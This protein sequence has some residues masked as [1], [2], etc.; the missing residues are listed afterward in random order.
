MA[1]GTINEEDDFDTMGWPC[2]APAAAPPPL[3]SAS[4]S[5]QQNATALGSPG[6]GESS[7]AEEALEAQIMAEMRAEAQAAALPQMQ[8]TQQ[9]AV[10]SPPRPAAVASP[11]SAVVSPTSAVASPPPTAASPQE[12]RVTVGL[13]LINDGKG[14]E[15]L[16]PRVKIQP[17]P[18]GSPINTEAKAPSEPSALPGQGS[19]FSAA[20]YAA[21]EASTTAPEMAKPAASPMAVPTTPA[22]PAAATSGT[23]RIAGTPR[24][25]TPAGRAAGDDAS[26]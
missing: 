25:G 24:G 17:S 7:E 6:P 26:A 3:S 19:A 1:D 10:A 13:S 21:Q 16:L 14:G 12:Q 9:A 11:T 5:P 15:M 22:Q 23:P 20:S 8:P 18:H 4:L 2:A